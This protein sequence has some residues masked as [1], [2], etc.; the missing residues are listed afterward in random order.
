MFRQH[1]TED[2]QQ[3]KA[4][5]ETANQ[6][7]P[8]FEHAQEIYEPRGAVLQAVGEGILAACF[9]GADARDDFFGKVV[10]EA[11]RRDFVALE[12]KQALQFTEIRFGLVHD[13]M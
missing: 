9:A 7:G 13:L 1:D 12:F 10:E 3:A 8:G 5:G 4:R 2:K 11:G 6:A